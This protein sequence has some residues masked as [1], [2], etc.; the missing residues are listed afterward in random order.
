MLIHT[1]VSV[2]RLRQDIRSLKLYHFHAGEGR[3]KA[4]II[5]FGASRRPR[6]ALDNVTLGAAQ[7]AL[8]S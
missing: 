7:F 3:E 5:S 1:G 2:P 6:F 8:V 4:A